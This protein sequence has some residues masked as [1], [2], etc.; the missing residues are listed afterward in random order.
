MFG[1]RPQGPRRPYCFLITPPH[2]TA[3]T[4]SP[5]VAHRPPTHGDPWRRQRWRRRRL[6]AA[7]VGQCFECGAAPPG[8]GRRCANGRPT[9]IRETRACECVS[10]SIS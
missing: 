1:T 5:C 3:P 9:L 7:R 4:L 6:S 10:F 2:V 8:I